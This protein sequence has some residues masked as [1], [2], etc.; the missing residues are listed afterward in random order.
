MRSISL[1]LI[2]G[3]VAAGEAHE[4]PHLLPLLFRQL[5]TIKHAVVAFLYPM[6]KGILL[7]AFQC[8]VFSSYSINREETSAAAM[9]KRMCL[10]IPAPLAC[11]FVA[12]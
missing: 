2:L 10:C 12:I 11:F 6:R 8:I 7:P 4:V 1:I 5:N 3:G 9:N